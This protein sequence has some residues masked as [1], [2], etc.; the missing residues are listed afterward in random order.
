[1]RM[2]AELTDKAGKVVSRKLALTGEMLMFPDL[3]PGNYGLRV[4][5]D[6]DQNGKWSAGDFRKKI[7]P[8]EVVYFPG[9]ILMRAGWDQEL[10]WAIDEQSVPGKR[11]LPAK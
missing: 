9:E 1:M 7:Q 10:S 6:K 5:W 3:L 4:I 8:E 11:L 2:V